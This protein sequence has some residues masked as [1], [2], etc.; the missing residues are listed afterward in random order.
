[1]IFPPSSVAP[2]FSPPPSLLPVVVLAVLF[3]ATPDAPLPSHLHAIFNG[4]FTYRKERE[5]KGLVLEYLERGVQAT[6]RKGRNESGVVSVT[7]YRCR[8]FMS[9]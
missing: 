6:M 1:M 5:K 2:F 9:A 8:K 4:V 3:P 7:R